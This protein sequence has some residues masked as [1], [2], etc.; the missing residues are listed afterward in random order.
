MVRASRGRG[1]EV[2]GAA[3]VPLGAE[4]AAPGACEEACSVLEVA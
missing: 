4:G 2:D 1:A 3:P